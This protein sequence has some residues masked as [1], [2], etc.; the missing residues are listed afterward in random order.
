MAKR[1]PRNF[2]PDPGTI[3]GVPQKDGLLRLVQIAGYHYIGEQRDRDKP[4]CIIFD[5]VRRAEDKH[6]VSD[7]GAPLAVVPTIGLSIRDH[8]WPAV[9]FAPVKVPEAI[10]LVE[11]LN[12]QD[13]MHIDIM[14]DPFFQSFVNALAG[15]EPWDHYYRPDELDRRLLPGV[16]RPKNVMLTRSGRR[17]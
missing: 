14:N 16:E 17:E 13:G 2:Y 4:V 10:A 9:G 15:L 1:R 3:F 8:T 7:P 11:R 6:Q 12:E 5:S